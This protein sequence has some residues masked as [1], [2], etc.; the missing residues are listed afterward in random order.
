MLNTDYIIGTVFGIFVA[1]IITH[2]LAQ[3]R[4]RKL[5]KITAFTNAADKFRAAFFDTIMNFDEGAHAVV[6]L[7]EHF[8]HEHKYAMLAFKP[9]LSGCSLCDFDKKWKEYD[10]YCEGFLGNSDNVYIR[11]QS[12]E[13]EVEQ[14][15]RKI[16]R[17]HI[18]GLLKFT[19]V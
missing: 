15:Q 10:S 14:N 8:F 6:W 18:D 5:L 16:F 7:V 19:D 3:R 2:F 9:L 13:T 11:F 4:D 1:A 17:N 12:T